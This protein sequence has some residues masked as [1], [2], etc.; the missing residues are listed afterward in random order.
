MG[1]EEATAQS[2]AAQ[3]EKEEAA[4]AKKQARKDKAWEVG[5]KDTSK[6]AASAEKAAATAERKAAA[7]AQ[8]ADEEKMGKS[9]KP[10]EDSGA[11]AKES[12]TTQ[13]ALRRMVG[14]LAALNDVPMITAE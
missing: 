3:R 6:D 11:P 10:K 2:K 8:A 13:A 7:A 9:T 12:N 1:R 14:G 5:A 4:H